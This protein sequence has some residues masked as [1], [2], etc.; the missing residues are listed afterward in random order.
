MIIYR[1]MRDSVV[2]PVILVSSLTTEIVHLI[3]IPMM[4]VE[5]GLY[6]SNGISI[7][8]HQSC[9]WKTHGNDVSGH[10]GQVKIH[11]ILLVTPLVL[12]SNLKGSRSLDFEKIQRTVSHLGNFLTNGPFD[13]M[14]L[15]VNPKKTKQPEESDHT[16]ND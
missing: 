8:R 13:L 6:F 9:A 15:G 12:E 1:P 2:E 4:L 3:T 11:T 7:P 14:V 10:I 16:E 5:K